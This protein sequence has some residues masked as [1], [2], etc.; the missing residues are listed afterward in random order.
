MVIIDR[1]VLPLKIQLKTFFNRQTFFDSQ[2]ERVYNMIVES[3]ICRNMSKV[4]FIFK[5]RYF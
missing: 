3:E 1:L 4:H 2:M 5:K